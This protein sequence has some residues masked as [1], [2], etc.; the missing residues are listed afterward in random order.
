MLS[1]F[2]KSVV[3]LSKWNYIFLKPT[4]VWKT[5]IAMLW[6]EQKGVPMTISANQIN[7]VTLTII[8]W[9]WSGPMPCLST[10][11]HKGKTHITH[12]YT[13]TPRHIPNN[14]ETIRKCNKTYWKKNLLSK[15]V[16]NSARVSEVFFSLPKPN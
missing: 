14:K 10:N 3:A 9:T 12:T 8:L 13:H 1:G 16:F 4:S 5:T 11:F 6:D 15:D 7:I 2:P